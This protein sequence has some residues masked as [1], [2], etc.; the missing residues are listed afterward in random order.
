M[1]KIIGAVIVYGFA[2]YGLSTFYHK[3]IK[4]KKEQICE[5]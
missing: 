4:N 5:E 1:F 2:A 3:F